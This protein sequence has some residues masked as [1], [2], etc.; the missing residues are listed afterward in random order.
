MGTVYRGLHRPSGRAVAIKILKPQLSV[1]QSHRLWREAVTGSR[2][3]HP[4]IVKVLDVGTNDDDQL[5]L[6]MELL[7]GTTLASELQN[8]G[9]FA[10]ERAVDLAVQTLTGIAAAHELEILHRDLKPANIFLTRDGGEE[11]VKIVDFGLCLPRNQAELTRLTKIGSVVGTTRYMSPEQLQG[12][13]DIGPTTDLFS[14]AIVLYRM[15]TGRDAVSGDHPRGASS[16]NARARGGADARASARDPPSNSSRWWLPRCRRS[17]RIRYASA[18]QLRERL[19]DAVSEAT[20]RT[21]RGE[22]PV[23]PRLRGRA[24]LPGVASAPGGVGTAGSGGSPLLAYGD[25]AEVATTVDPRPPGAAEQPDRGAFTELS[26]GATVDLRR[27]ANLVL[28]PPLDGAPRTPASP[29]A[30]ARPSC[31]WSPMGS[32]RRSRRSSPQRPRARPWRSILFFAVRDRRPPGLC[33]CRQP[34][35]IS[36]PRTPPPADGHSAGHSSGDHSMA[37]ASETDA[38]PALLVEGALG[39][40]AFALV[41]GAGRPFGRRRRRV[42]D[43]RGRA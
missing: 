5:F 20:V 14:V 7:V 21:P 1:R 32:L 13:R 30:E 17:P 29:A 40:G 27:P 39:W 8:G 24:G 34:P 43:D 6:V 25:G 41:C 28:V 42:G 38:S 10:I 31:G 18:R 2:L 26:A 16:A 11:R 12:V 22:E 36:A 9:P 23:S 15:L 4:N 37:L 19:I 33:R 35:A 3:Q